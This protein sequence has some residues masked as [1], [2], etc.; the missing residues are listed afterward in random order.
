MPKSKEFLTSSEC[1]IY[2][3]RMELRWPFPTTDKDYHGSVSRKVK[4]SLSQPTHTVQIP[5]HEGNEKDH[6]DKNRR[7]PAQAVQI[8]EHDDDE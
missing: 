7:H 8:S 6:H 5:T 4:Q 2:G 3:A 1:D